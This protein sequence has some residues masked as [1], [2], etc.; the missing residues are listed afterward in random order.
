VTRHERQQ[1]DYV[2]PTHNQAIGPGAMA[3]VAS[4]LSDE[5][6][7]AVITMRGLLRPCCLA[8]SRC[9]LTTRRAFSS[10]IASAGGNATR[11][12]QRRTRR[13]TPRNSD[14][15]SPTSLFPTLLVPQLNAHPTVPGARR[16]KSDTSADRA[17]LPTVA[18]LGGGLTGLA[19]A[20]YLTRLAKG[21]NV[22]VYE[23]QDR[24]GGWI[25]SERQTVSLPGGGEGELLFE[26]AAR[27]V[28]TQFNSARYDDL[29]LW[30]LVR[31]PLFFSFF[32]FSLFL[33]L[34]HG[35]TIWIFG[36]LLCGCGGEDALKGWTNG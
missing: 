27:T 9:G 3:P 26:R 12:S 11:P 7:R 29:V 30:E 24:L 4:K 21:L 15:T 2:K 33:F 19:T 35:L 13:P 16:H 28:K 10:A 25:G 31:F 22:V 23:A 32:F 5:A 8:R 20:W 1:Q 6:F 17:E 36:I 34:Y 18:V 14:T